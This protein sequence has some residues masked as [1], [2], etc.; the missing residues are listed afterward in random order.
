VQSSPAGF[1]PAKLG[2]FQEHYMRELPAGR[3][4]EL[5]LPFLERAGLVASPSDETTQQTVAAIVEAAGDRITAAGDVLDYADFFTADDELAYDEQAF[6]KRLRKPPEARE[7]LAGF[8]DRLAS[9]DRFDA[10]SLEMLL[11]EYVEERGVKLGQV[12]H[13]LRV[14]VTGKPVGFGMF[15]ILEIL[16]RESCS[17]RIDNALKQL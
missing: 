7:L 17:S 16:G 11:R 13:A 4:V 6:D 3:R 5:C 12:I 2:A 14:A 8:R 10:A 15:E 1:D 9:A